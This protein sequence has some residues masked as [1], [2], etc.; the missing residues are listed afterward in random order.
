M[1]KS[2]IG[3]GNAIVTEQD[4]QTG[5]SIQLQGATEI[6]G[7]LTVNTG[8]QGH[9]TTSLLVTTTADRSANDGP[10]VVLFKN[11]VPDD[12][13][14]LGSIRFQ[15]QDAGSTKRTYA[16]IDTFVR[17]ADDGAADGAMILSALSHGT[18]KQGL[19]IRSSNNAADAKVQTQVVNGPI[20]L[21]QDTFDDDDN[22]PRVDGGNIFTTGDMNG[23]SVKITQL[24]NAAQGQI[25]ILT[26]ADSGTAPEID[27]GGNFILSGNWAPG[28][29]DTIVL[30]TKDS[31]NWREI[32][33]TNN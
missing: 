6:F 8:G 32:S 28:S 12:N 33:R 29:H 14:Y 27:D 5:Q 19:K 20:L 9:T 7:Q 31:T 26:V 17:D 30:F 15:S 11:S 24:D 2:I 22:T 13:D 21:Q 23:A 16:E 3:S 25:V 1:G 18:M 4:K 10:D